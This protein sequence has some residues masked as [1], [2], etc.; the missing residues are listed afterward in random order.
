[1]VKPVIKVAI[2]R[3]KD[4]P[5]MF[6]FVIITPFMKSQFILPREMLN[7]MRI[8]IERVLFSKRDKSL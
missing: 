6:E 2:R 7:K 1:M 3:V 8:A 4:S 5:N